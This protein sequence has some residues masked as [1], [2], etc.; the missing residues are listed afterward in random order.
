MI[1]KWEVF[2]T[3]RTFP[4]SGRPSKHWMEEQQE[5][6]KRGYQEAHGHFEGVTGIWRI[7]CACVNNFTSA[8][9]MW[10]VPEE[11]GKRPRKGSFE[12]CQNATCRILPG[13]NPMQHTIPTVW[14]R[15]NVQFFRKYTNIAQSKCTK[16]L[17]RLVR[18][19]SKRWSNK[20]LTL[21][22]I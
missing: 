4:G 7:L 17:N 16:Y 20:I 6:A 15:N 8:T 1:K 3:T 10:N 19:S 14:G 18:H 5:T 12:L 21:T 13:E 22:L 11:K 9:Q 2:G